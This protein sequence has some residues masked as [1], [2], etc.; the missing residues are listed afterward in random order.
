ML[1]VSSGQ[2]PGPVSPSKPVLVRLALLAIL[3]LAACLYIAHQPPVVVDDAPITYRYAE[4]VARGIGFVY[5]EGETIIGTTTPLYT[6]LLAAA[7]LLGAPIPIASQTMGFLASLA[8]ITLIYMLARKLGGESVGLLAALLVALNWWSIVFA[9]GGMETPLYTLL[10]VAAL[11]A[12]DPD[13]PT[14]SIILAALCVWMRLDGAIVGAALLG[15]YALTWR[16]IPWRQGLLLGLLIAPWFLF[17]LIYTGA[18]FPH[19]L[20]GKQT[21]A[22]ARGLFEPENLWVFHHTLFDAPF[23]R[24]M[25]VGLAALLLIAR[26]WSNFRRWMPTLLWFGGY[27]LAYFLVRIEEYQWYLV[28]PTVVMCLFLAA[29]ARSLADIAS[30]ALREQGER[31]HTA[32]LASGALTILLAFNFYDGLYARVEGYNAYLA[33][34]EV[35]RLHVGDWL[36]DH[37]HICPSVA[38]GAIGHIGY[39]ALDTYILDGAGLVTAF[40]PD[41]N[42]LRE[43]LSRR[44]IRCYVGIN[45]WNGQPAYGI[46]EQGWF[47]AAYQLAFSTPV[48]AGAYQYEVW[49]SVGSGPPGYR[50]WYDRQTVREHLPAPDTI[51]PIRAAWIGGAPTNDVTPGE[52]RIADLTLDALL[53]VPFYEGIP[54]DVPSQVWMPLLPTWAGKQLVFLAAMAPWAGAR[55][56]D[57]VTFQFSL[58]DEAAPV[59]M[60]EAILSAVFVDPHATD[61]TP[62]FID[63]FPDMVGGRLLVTL[64]AGATTF[65]DHTLLSFVGITDQ[66]PAER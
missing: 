4:N 16:R 21:H 53:I 31:R 27:L 32:L 19:S 23:N 52:W 66:S 60:P 13:R 55:D 44:D 11:Y 18:L 46:S 6:L 57:G 33:D 28:P 58:T 42:T 14:L 51:T 48:H 36:A 20:A 10:I 41:E 24:V 29:G 45:G 47:P 17:S 1:T 30:A 56:S 40:A 50:L 49:V 15:S 64:D 35:A 63:V 5:N 12:Y 43:R 54:A 65:N 2:P 34:Y 26:R 22:A 7:R 61:W 3:L 59:E 39:R 25:A 9:L 62:I 38:V 37:P 8:T